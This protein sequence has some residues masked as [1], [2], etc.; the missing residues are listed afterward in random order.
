MLNFDKK[1]VKRKYKEYM[2][3]IHHPN[4]FWIVHSIRYNKFTR[5]PRDTKLRKK[6]PCKSF[7]IK[8]IVDKI[9]RQQLK[10][11]KFHCEQS[12]FLN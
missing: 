7:F 11:P 3:E 4:L 8:Q 9:E 12:A 2:P 10:M 1:Y 5:F 6:M